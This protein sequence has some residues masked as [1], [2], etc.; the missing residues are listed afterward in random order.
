[1]W[2]FGPLC[3]GR[4]SPPRRFL[5][6]ASQLSST[7]FMTSL[8]R[9]LL[10]SSTQGKAKI[11]WSGRIPTLRH[12]HCV[13]CQQ[14]L[15]A[16]LGVVPS[17]SARGQGPEKKKLGPPLEEK[18][19]SVKKPHTSVLAASA[20]LRRNPRSRK[21]STSTVRGILVGRSGKPLAVEVGAVRGH[22][23]CH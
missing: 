5:V 13:A 3:Q 23:L 12:P 4:L 11:P 17:G 20:P 2:S 21:H 6:G 10:L 7:R 15:S 19:I 1:M 8:L 14:T 22:I 9:L 16:R 18:L